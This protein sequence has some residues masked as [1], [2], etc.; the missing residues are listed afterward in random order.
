MQKGKK[1]D[2]ITAHLNQDK[3]K[4]NKII[5]CGGGLSA[6]DSALE[7]AMEDKNTTIIEMLGEVAINDHF[8]NKAALIP[9]LKQ[10]KVEIYTNHK[11]LEITSEGVKTVSKDGNDVF[12]KGGDTIVSAFGMRPNN[13]LAEKISSKYHTKTCIVGDCQKVGKVGNAVREGFY[14]GQ[15]IV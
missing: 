13:S 15:Y 14:A 3:L 6:C 2:I 8:I 5:Y 4:G 11:V 1:I 12:I 9:M 10:H 7:I